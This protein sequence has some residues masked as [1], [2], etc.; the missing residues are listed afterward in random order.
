LIPGAGSASDCSSDLGVTLAHQ[1]TTVTAGG[2][3]TFLATVSNSA[4]FVST[5]GL[6]TVAITF[7]PSLTPTLASGTGWTCGIAGQVVTCT[8]ND[9]LAAKLSYP[10]ISITVNVLAGA[11]S[12]PTRRRSQMGGLQRC[13]QHVRRPVGVRAPTLAVVRELQGCASA[14]QCICAGVR[15]RVQAS[16]SDLSSRALAAELVTP[17]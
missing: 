7:D 15:R 1:E 4:P 8:R 14:A 13:Q 3:A 2:T 10:P 12:F 16:V 5:S 11:E 17:P 9:A 6:V